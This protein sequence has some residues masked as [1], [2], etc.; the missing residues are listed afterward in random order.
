MKKVLINPPPKNRRCQCCGMQAVIR[1]TFRQTDPLGGVSASWECQSCINLDYKSY[2]KKKNNSPETII[3]ELCP[4]CES[5]VTLD[6]VFQIQECPSCGKPIKP[7]SMCDMNQVN[8]D[9]CKL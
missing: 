3:N 7:C 4:R 8:C 1:K 6:K 9:E 5:E 2:R